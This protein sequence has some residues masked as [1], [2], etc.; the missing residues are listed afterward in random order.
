M[1][2]VCSYTWLYMYIHVHVY[3]CTYNVYYKPSHAGSTVL[4]IQA[5][6]GT[7][8]SADHVRPH[9]CMYTLNVMLWVCGDSVTLCL[10]FCVLPAARSQQ[11]SHA[12]AQC[13]GPHQ[14]A[15]TKPRPG[16]LITDTHTTTTTTTTVPLRL[17][18]SHYTRQHGHC[19]TSDRLYHYCNY[20]LLYCRRRHLQR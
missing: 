11:L 14:R 7:Q 3:T 5:P 6:E 9:S 10:L 20:S 12:P 18:L 16:T 8:L 17:R 13:R 2:N 4:A 15:G 1:F 19:S